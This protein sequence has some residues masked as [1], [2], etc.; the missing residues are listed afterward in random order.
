MF[1]DRDLSL[2]N[3]VIAESYV[4]HVNGHDIPNRDAGKAFVHALITAFPNLHY[5]VEDTIVQGDQGR[6]PLVRHRHARRSLSGMPPTNRDV[7]K[8]GITIFR[9]EDG[10]MVEL[11]NVWDQHGLDGAIDVRRSGGYP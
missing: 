1:N 5:T 8:V 9:I 7:I 3:E 6:H 4:G 2:W 10:K 11:W